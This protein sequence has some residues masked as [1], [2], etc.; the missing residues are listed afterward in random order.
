MNHK[1]HP[2]ELRAGVN[3]IH[4]TDEQGN[5]HIQT[6]TGKHIIWCETDPEGFN[7]VHHPIELTHEVFHSIEFIGEQL[8]ET[9][10][11]KTNCMNINI[12]KYEIVRRFSPFVILAEGF[13]YL[14]QLQDLN[15]SITGIK[16]SIP[17]NTNT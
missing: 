17:D 1:F 2:S 9:P 4:Y 6:V 7:L 11:L 14:H 12:D 5:I 8:Y 10:Y 16:V 15:F 13:K 3:Q